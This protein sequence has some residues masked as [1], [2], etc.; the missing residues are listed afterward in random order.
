MMLMNPTSTR[1]KKDPAHLRSTPTITPVRQ[2]AAIMAAALL[3]TGCATSNLAPVTL[4][5]NPQ[6]TDTA[7]TINPDLRTARNNNTNRHVSADFPPH[8][9]V[10]PGTSNTGID[11]SKHFFHTSETLVIT[12]DSPTDQLRAASLAIIS[13]SP[14]L[15]MTDTNRTAILQEI[16]RL[17]AH[18]VLL[19]G[20]VP[21]ATST[22][23]VD[24]I[25]DPGT[26]EALGKLTAL[27][28]T[29]KTIANQHD[30][31]HTIASLD[32]DTAIELVAGWA[33]AH[34]TS[35]TQHPT[36][37]RDL[38]AFPAQSRR[39]ADI[40]PIV[41]AT[42]ESSVA[43]IATAKA[44]GA[45]VRV[46]AQPD[47]RYDLT[48]LKQVAVL[49]DQ[50]LIALGPQFGTA[51]VL[52]ER[53]RQGE[54]TWQYQPGSGKR[55]TVYPGRIVVTRSLN[56]AAASPENPIDMDGEFTELLD[57]VERYTPELDPTDHAAHIDHTDQ[58][59][60]RQVT[61]G[62]ILTVDGLRPEQLRIW[63]D[64]AT[65]TNAYLLLQG[66]LEHLKT[67]ESIFAHP[68]VGLATIGG[69]NE[70]AQWL[71]GF[72]KTNRLPQKLVVNQIPAGNTTEIEA[73]NSDYIAPVA[74]ITAETWE[75]YHTVVKH[76]PAGV[77]PGLSFTTQNPSTASDIMKFQPQPV[78]INR[79]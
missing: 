66:E 61:P 76:L 3:T 35:H 48:T 71:A 2:V 33:D 21:L 47:P 26:P 19:V 9:V 16:Q 34:P 38:R 17:G 78:A 8:P 28:F 45:T 6:P 5:T 32:G 64:E 29:T 62:F 24:Y 31:P 20:D 39:D 46:L 12:T 23:Q 7:N 54:I 72:T 22:G 79:M 1:A 10:L 67:F 42:A 14:L 18:A 37:P 68:N 56:L 60:V 69:D 63:L 75:E 52:A 51:E 73:V 59:G 50:P 53:I 30:V 74:L 55:G 11:A 44:F 49:A 77:Q 13:H 36:T 15:T 70:A 25:K 27:Q 4:T 40:A 43:D 58:D 41:I 57:E 65:R